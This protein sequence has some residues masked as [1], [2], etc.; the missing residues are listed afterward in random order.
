MSV[1]GD[2]RGS[3]THKNLGYLQMRRIFI[4]LKSELQKHNYFHE[5]RKVTLPYEVIYSY[6]RA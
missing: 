5:I 4:L 6:E 1:F 3:M 2:K